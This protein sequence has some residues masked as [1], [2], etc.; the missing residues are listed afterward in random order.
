[1]HI[2]LNIH[3]RCK[4]CDQIIHDTLTSSSDQDITIQNYIENLKTQ[5]FVW[6]TCPHCDT[7]TKQE[8]VA[9]EYEEAVP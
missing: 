1:M 3:Y 2:I 8:P 4:R 5:L 6:R 9:I 7:V